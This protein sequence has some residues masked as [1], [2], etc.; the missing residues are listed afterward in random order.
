MSTGNENKKTV[1][2]QKNSCKATVPAAK[3]AEWESRGW[4]RIGTVDNEDLNDK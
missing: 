4:K 2:V 1:Q 3:L